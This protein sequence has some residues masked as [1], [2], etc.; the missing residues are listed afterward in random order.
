[1]TVDGIDRLPGILEAA[2]PDLAREMDLPLDAFRRL[3]AI[4]SYYLRYYYEFDRV[5][6]KQLGGQNRATEVMDIEARLLEMYRDP[7]LDQKPALLADRG[8]AFYSEAAA[9]L[10]EGLTVG[11][12]DPQV[13]DLRNDGALAE[14]AAGDV[15]EVPAR[16]DTGGATPLPQRPLPEE[17]RDLVLAAKQYERLAV[18]AA[19][20]GDRA[21][22]LAAL[23][24]NP[25][26]AGHADPEPLLDA[27]LEA[28]RA[29]LPA[30]FR[31]PSAA[32][33]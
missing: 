14:L 9:Q 18:K 6:A 16:I 4:P 10:V 8:G 24:A 3:D 23:A 21:D 32:D 22:A 26:V 33:A 1:V 25:L 19:R 12:D 30:F 2:G 29:S 7:Q 11:A 20:S 27:L 28:N 31:E 5:L 17:L 13:V 15:V